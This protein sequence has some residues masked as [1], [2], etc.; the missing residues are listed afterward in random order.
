VLWID[1][2]HPPRWAIRF[3]RFTPAGRPLSG[4]TTL[5]GFE[6]YLPGPPGHP[7][8]INVQPIQW[9]L[10][11]LRAA[12]GSVWAAW[13]G[14]QNQGRDWL[15]VAQWTR[16]G[17]LT[18][19]PTQVLQGGFDSGV[20]DLRSVS[21]AI[22]RNGGQLYF[23]GPDDG[24]GI[25]SVPYVQPFDRDGNPVG[26]PQRVAYDG[27]GTDANPHAATVHARAQV[28]WEKTGLHGTVLE[29]TRYQPATIPP[30]LLVRLGLNV[31]NLAINILFVVLGSL[32]GGIGIAAIN[33]IVLFPLIL[34]WLPVGWVVPRRLRWTVYLA[35]LGLVLAAIF[36]SGAS[37][38]PYVI[39]IGA[40]GSPGG[41]I[42]VAAAVF[43]AF[44]AGQFV[45][46]RFDALFRAAAIASTSVYVIGT[47]YAVIYIQDQI[48][49]I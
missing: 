40:L 13:E 31:G 49:R 21:L 25:G 28:I 9:A 33:P 37:P 45:F 3:Q 26:L 7:P 6:Y 35:L 41:W 14:N 4:I 29:G 11:V 43:I 5:D 2:T 15:S 30:S 48:T 18:L 46:R 19:P 44:W 27:G 36:R 24:G 8:I 47:L 1:R 10:D 16:N 32:A 34:L 17:H 23:T 38:P 22:T 12:D 20:H 39:F 42:A